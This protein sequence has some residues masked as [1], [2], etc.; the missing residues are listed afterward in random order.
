MDFSDIMKMIKDPQAMQAQAAQL[1]AK[2]A[3]I[4]VT[5][6]SGGGMV[7]ITMNGSFEMKACIIAPEIIDPSDA[8][9]I[10][11]L[12]RAAYNDAMA[13]IREELGREFSM[14]LGGL[15][16]PPGFPAGFPGGGL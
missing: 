3:A 14:G 8:S 1:Q 7:K 10:Q 2:T 12:V 16:L 6:S 15:G 5:G 11:D 9:L 13:K 4:E